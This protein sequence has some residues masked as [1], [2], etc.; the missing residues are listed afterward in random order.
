M[1]F[2]IDSLAQANGQEC[3]RSVT[4]AGSSMLTSVPSAV[5]NDNC[6]MGKA[7]GAGKPPAIPQS[8]EKE[9]NY[10]SSDDGKSESAR[11]I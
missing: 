7:D 6:V 3:C 1:D 11:I 2:I 10:D 4:L 8:L 9:F 5:L